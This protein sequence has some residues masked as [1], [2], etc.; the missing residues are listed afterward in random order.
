MRTCGLIEGECVEKVTV[1]LEGREV[2]CMQT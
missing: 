1:C 2:V